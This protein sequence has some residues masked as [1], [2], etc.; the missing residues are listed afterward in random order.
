MSKFVIGD[1]LE[2]EGPALNVDLAQRRVTGFS[3]LL[4]KDGPTKLELD[5]S[6]AG[7]TPPPFGVAAASTITWKKDDATATTGGIALRKNGLAVL[8]FH[9]PNPLTPHSAG[10]YLRLTVHKTD[11]DHRLEFT[12]AIPDE[13]RAN[14]QKKNGNWDEFFLADKNGLVRIADWRDQWLDRFVDSVDGKA[15]QTSAL[16][17]GDGSTLI[18]DEPDDDEWTFGLR[19]AAGANAVSRAVAAVDIKD[20]TFALSMRALRLE[21]RDDLQPRPLQWARRLSLRCG[22]VRSDTVVSSWA[23]DWLGVPT[24]DAAAR[25]DHFSL[26]AFWQELARHWPLGLRS[27]RSRNALTFLPT[28]ISGGGETWTFR[29]ACER[30][31]QGFQTRL[32]TIGRDGAAP[33]RVELGALTDL[34]SKPCRFDAALTATFQSIAD[35]TE[36]NFP[37]PLAD[38]KFGPSAGGLGEFLVGGLVLDA[39]SLR[40]GS[41]QI[42]WAPVRTQL[43]QPPIAVDLSFTADGRSPRP[44]TED[45]ESRFESENDILERER[46]LVVDLRPQVPQATEIGIREVA[47]GDRSRVLEVLVRSAQENL[48]AG[49]ADVVVIDPAPLLVARVSSTGQPT[50]KDTILA[51]YR[52]DGEQPPGWELH[53]DTG[54]MTLV[55]PPQAIGEEMI[56]GKLSVD[57]QGQRTPVPFKDRPFDFRLSPPALLTLDRTDV[58]T[59]RA[60]A[61]WALRRLLDRRLGVVGLKLDAARFELLYGLTSNIGNAAG[62][63]VAEQDAFVGRIPITPAL[64]DRARKGLSSDRRFTPE[65]R[66]YSMA[67]VRWIR[68][69]FAR[70]AQ[71]PVFRD[72]ANRD[73]LVVRDGVTFSFRPTRQTVHPIRIDER[74]HGAVESPAGDFD[75]L[76]L[77]GGVDFPFESDNIYVAVN[78]HDKTMPGV[79]QGHVGGLV[80]GALGGSGSQQASFDEGRSI[81]ISETTQGRLDSLTLIRIGRIAMLWHPARHVIVYERTTRTVP[82]YRNEQP[83]DFE[84]LAALRK[85]KEYVEVTHPRRTYPDFPAG[86]DARPAAGPLTGCAFETEVIP[87]KSSWGYDIEEGWVMALR[88]PL[89]P[90]EEQFYPMPK[91]FLELARADAKGG[92]AINHLAEDPGQLHFF[93]TTRKGL[94]ADT[95]RWPA[96]P[97]VDFPLTQRPEAPK[98]RF[99]PGFS[100]SNHQ[101]DAAMHDYGQRRFTIDV[102]P[103][104][105]AANLLHG[106]PGNGLEARVR[107]VSLLRGGASNARSAI[108]D[109][110]GKKFAD[111]EAQIADSLTELAQ[112]FERMGR[113]AP[114]ATVAELGGLR[115]EARALLADARSR[116]DDV[117]AAVSG[118]KAALDAGIDDWASIQKRSLDNVAKG[119]EIALTESVVLFQNNL[120]DVVAHLAGNKPLDAARASARA[121]S[122]SVCR[123]AKQRIEG[124]PFLGVEIRNRLENELRRVAG[125]LTAEKDRIRALWIAKLD[126]VIARFPSASATALE[127]DFFDAVMQGRARL[128]AFAAT[129]GRVIKGRLGPLFGDIVG[130]D[131]AVGRLTAAIEELVASATQGIDEAIEEIP[132]FGVIPPDREAILNLL[133]GVF[134]D[135]QLPFDEIIRALLQPLQAPVADWQT[136]VG[137]QAATLETFCRQ[138]TQRLLDAIDQGANA[139]DAIAGTIVSDWNTTVASALGSLRGDAATALTTFASLP[140]AKRLAGITDRAK[141]L[142]DEVRDAID[143]LESALDDPANGVHALAGRAN[144]LARRAGTGLRRVGEQIEQAVTNELRHAAEGATSAALELT[145]TLAEG[146]ITDTLRCTRDRLGYYYD[147]ARD[148]LDV[149]R[150]AA[151]FNDLGNGVL[152]SLSAQVPFDRIRDRL[153][154]Q[155]GNFDVNKLFPDFA[156]LKLEHLLSGLTI[157][158]DP[159]AEYDWI[160]MRHGFDR[161][162]LTA[163]SEISID[164]QFDDAPE[165]F[166]LPPVTL[167]VVRPRFTATSRI[168]V[169]ANGVRAQKTNALLV[170]D[171]TVTLNG[172]PI[173]SIEKGGLF[174]DGSGG[175]R[176]DFGSNDL[177][178]APALQFVTDALRQFLS[179]DDGLTITPILPGGISVELSLPLPDIGTGA[180]T[181]TGITLYTH[182]D[183]LVAAGFEVRTGLWLSRPERPFGMAILFLGG[184]GWFG[185]DVRYKPPREFE[186][187]V[188]LGLAAGAFV[189]LNFGVARGSAGILFTVGLDFYRNWLQ[190]GSQDLAISIGILVWGEFS[191]L[192]IVS[193][194]LRVILRVEYRNGEMTGYGSVSVSIKI[195]WCFTLRVNAPIRLPFKSSSKKSVQSQSQQALAAAVAPPAMGAASSPPTLAQILDAHFANLDV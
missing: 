154:A 98:V 64:R 185:V 175:F 193:A 101:P 30:A 5:A 34:K 28:D 82:R 157:P 178:L 108:D 138:Q 136:K 63:R 91:I 94:G 22:G 142:Q 76:R 100:G 62:L 144:E 123:Q 79:P 33:C 77:R 83:A 80:F 165:L 112:H 43:G 2:V 75:R 109:T 12:K 70:P 195:C 111:A 8:S 180:F 114:D 176:F 147:T 191:I 1:F 141:F 45:P 152:N 155:L 17:T 168:E 99:L 31:G 149:T 32:A 97:D 186:T 160:K 159:L 146:P 137:A 55:L 115:E 44:G 53:T 46:P 65:E 181:L 190:D 56:K 182:F 81:I 161:D 69:L 71:L 38:W 40:G 127:S 7:V 57:Q 58:D 14:I 158:E 73:R 19:F 88:G 59:A 51:S 95:D 4:M 130:D 122:E 84:G 102:V 166:T 87:V 49:A 177:Q 50:P 162:R 24:F 121:A 188:S 27:L 39:A 139:L 173:M 156:G 189:A 184:G 54:V 106:R 153:L 120:T 129:A 6:P 78:E 192:S 11:T 119:A 23:V 163:W 67:A 3:R 133:D 164:K 107:N 113:R 171:W 145:R 187:R 174:F 104:E 85:V 172:Q 118:A 125:D 35:V 61:P 151:V 16:F 96:W 179:P 15:I 134:P 103:P 183:L 72:F 170:A 37:P 105:E 20:E 132:P 21:E 90:D 9:W 131:G 25:K 60:A 42:D 29:Y 140:E 18:G 52:D 169:D 117:I 148:A 194:Y 89:L 167:S 36:S 143:R 86:T 135:L 128:A 150:A 116:T 110:V 26:R 66:N 126:D 124:V 48:I 13:G 47:A 10:I 68:G 93:T 92:G 74:P 41:L